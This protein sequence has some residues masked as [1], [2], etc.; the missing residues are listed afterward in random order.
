MELAHQS[1]PAYLVSILD[2]FRTAVEQDEMSVIM[3]LLSVGSRLHHQ[4]QLVHIWAVE[5]F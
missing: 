5:E 3:M 2:A 4:K 1:H